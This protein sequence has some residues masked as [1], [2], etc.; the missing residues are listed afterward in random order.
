MFSFNNEKSLSENLTLLVKFLTG[1]NYPGDT[2]KGLVTFEN[3]GEKPK[4]WEEDGAVSE[5][6]TQTE[7]VQ[8]HKDQTDKYESS[9]SRVSGVFNRAS[10]S[11]RLLVDEDTVSDNSELYLSG[12]FQLFGYFSLNSEIID[13]QKFEKLRSESIISGC[14][15]GIPSLKV[16]QTETKSFFQNIT[17]LLSGEISNIDFF[18]K[19]ANGNFKN[20]Q[21]IFST[22]QLLVFSVLRLLPGDTKQYYVEFKL[23]KN[24]PPSYQLK[25]IA[26]NYELIFNAEK[27]S[28]GEPSNVNISFPLNVTIPEASEGFQVVPDLSNEFSFNKRLL[29]KKFSCESVIQE[30]SDHY[31]DFSFLHNLNENKTSEAPESASDDV[32]SAVNSVDQNSKLRKEFINTMKALIN[33]RDLTTTEQLKSLPNSPF[34]E[35]LGFSNLNIHSALDRQQSFASVYSPVFP[36]D[37][38]HKYEPAL[39]EQYLKNQYVIKFKNKFV[40]KLLYDKTYYSVGDVINISFDFSN[41]DPTIKSHAI[42]GVTIELESFEKVNYEYLLE[43]EQSVNCI[44]TSFQEDPEKAS[45]IWNVPKSDI[46]GEYQKLTIDEIN[47]SDGIEKFI[48][49]QNPHYWKDFFKT[50]WTKKYSMLLSNYSILN[51]NNLVVGDDLPPQLSTNFFK[52]R[53]SL[54]FKFVIVNENTEN[55]D[56]IY[57]QRI[58]DNENGTLYSA[59]NNLLGSTFSVKLPMNIVGR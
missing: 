18:L 50:H 6:D 45:K 17:T 40:C 29:Q 3:I 38:I 21:P 53:Y 37:N 51:A 58:N 11:E 16:S 8:N 48:L 46:T 42:S 57:L 5:N 39:H 56:E 10:I 30:L 2:V 15:G 27:V 36:K 9:T 4:R 12:S 26:I 32:I 20:I 59:K 28:H 52:V 7:L 55:G 23:P 47:N 24:L 19:N 1:L 33:E 41:T 49:D 43:Y 14:I 44:Y 54:V 35:N 25:N 34:M 22:S 31:T 13:V